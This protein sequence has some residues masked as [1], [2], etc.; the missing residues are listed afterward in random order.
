VDSGFRRNDEKKARMSRSSPP[1]GWGELL[2]GAN[3]A[4]VAVIGGGMIL[5]AINSFIVV[6]I[7]PTVVRDIGGLRFF[8]WST[9]L[10]LVASLLSGA[11]CTRMLRG[12]GARWT[13]RIALGSFLAGS[14]LCAIAPAM[15]VLLL[16][17]AVQGLGAGTLSALSYTLV[18]ILFA[19]HLWPR[20][21]SITSAMWGIATLLGP[22]VGGM[23]AEYDAWR[24]A[25]FSLAIITP[26]FA[27]LVEFTLPRGLQRIARPAMSMAFV[28]LALLVGSVLI[29][30]AASVAPEARL[31][32]LGL[33][34]A[35]SGM[36]LFVRLEAG[37]GARLLPHAACNPFT[38]LGATY[39]AQAMLLIGM[40]VEVFVPYFLQTL[41]FLTPLWA[42]YL[43]AVMSGGWTIGAVFLAGVSEAASWL[44]IGAGPLSMLIGLAGM[45]LLMPIPGFSD[46][47]VAMLAVL[48]TLIGLGIGMCWPHLGVR[49]F[50]FA[51]EG[52]KDL[53][54]SAITIVVMV[55]QS[56][57]SALA[58]LVTNAAGLANPGGMAGAE[59]AS[60][61]LFGGFALAPILAGLAVRRLLA[62]RPVPA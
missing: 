3:G 31:N 5:H 22:A 35:L 42:G 1:G 23:F 47:T 10:Y 27:A 44:L 33:A 24:A 18:R 13:Y 30:S 48:L 46:L 6:T 39:A 38:P 61:W 9:T 62:L 11:I 2:R 55:A 50:R 40:T 28:N 58:G 16:G 17:R 52:E 54:A 59:S 21:L 14:L 8:A 7:L 51:P 60:V 57:G 49:I 26:G 4:R 41:H 56:F 45:A 19:E 29:V 34:V 53:A 43:T 15:P 37:G 20:A 25:F 32:A 12:V 36:A